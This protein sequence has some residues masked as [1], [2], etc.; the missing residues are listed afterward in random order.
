MAMPRVWAK[1]ERDVMAW[2]S[3]GA[4]AQMRLPVAASIL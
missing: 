1:N 4:K 3:S 2:S